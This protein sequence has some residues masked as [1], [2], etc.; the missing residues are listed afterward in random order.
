MATQTRFPTGDAAGGGGFDIF[1]VIPVTY[2][3]KVDDD[4]ADDDTTYIY[5]DP[6]QAL[7]AR[8]FS[9]SVFSIPAGSTI[10]NVT[11]YFKH[12]KV[13]SNASLI[14][15]VV[16]IDIGGGGTI[17]GSSTYVSPTKDVWNVSS[18]SYTTNPWTGSPWTI[19]EVNG[20]DVDSSLVAFGVHAATGAYD[21]AYCTQCYCEVNYNVTE[22]V[23]ISDDL[24]LT[25]AVETATSYNTGISIIDALTLTDAVTAGAIYPVT[26]SDSLSLTEAL[27]IMTTYTATIADVLTLSDSLLTAQSLRTDHSYYLASSTGNIYTFGETQLSDAGMA[28][29]SFWKSKRIDFADQHPDI[30]DKWK[31][32]YKITVHY[33]DLSASTLIVLHVS[34]DG[35]ANWTTSG[36]SVGTGAGTIKEKDFF[37]IKTGRMFNF[38]VESASTANYCKVIALEAEFDVGGEHFEV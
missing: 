38:K 14:K 20:V 23:T 34:T 4:P 28:V 2:W 27:T 16:V 13:G 17:I 31:T 30:I 33:E 25:D 19:D 15:G 21:S 12:K 29:S 18:K 8:Y 35:G 22:S 32:L 1:P 11:V 5:S 37:F 6:S 36:K 24:T 26:I 3:D 10:N 9:F 7:S